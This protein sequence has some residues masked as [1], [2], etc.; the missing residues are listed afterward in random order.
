MLWNSTFSLAL[1]HVVVQEQR[2]GSLG[3]QSGKCEAQQHWLWTQ[4]YNNSKFQCFCL[5]FKIYFTDV[6]AILR[7]NDQVQGGVYLMDKIVGELVVMN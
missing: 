5:G 2:Q 3:L 6:A 4:S 7:E 1:S